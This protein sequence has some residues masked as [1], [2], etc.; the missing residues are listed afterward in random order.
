MLWERNPHQLTSVDLDPSGKYKYV[1][2]KSIS[3]MFK[4]LSTEGLV[5]SAT[6]R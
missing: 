5:Q 3:L 6:F 1:S 4:L 2:E